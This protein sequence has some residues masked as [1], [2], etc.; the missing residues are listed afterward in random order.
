MFDAFIRSERSKL[1]ARSFQSEIDRRIDAR[2][3]KK[4]EPVAVPVISA[5]VSFFSKFLYTGIV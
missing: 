3:S 5:F 4:E 1:S 2:S